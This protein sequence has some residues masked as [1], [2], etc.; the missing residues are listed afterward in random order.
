MSTENSTTK[1][2]RLTRRDKQFVRAEVVSAAQLTGKRAFQYAWDG[3]QKVQITGFPAGR[4][5]IENVT[6][7]GVSIEPRRLLLAAG[8]PA[9][10]VGVAAAVLAVAA[11]VLR[12]AL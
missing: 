4:A 8:F 11:E 3:D 9:R 12:V 5:T 2:T 1:G 10:Y 7:A 6:E